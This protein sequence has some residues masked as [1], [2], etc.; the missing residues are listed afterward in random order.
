MQVRVVLD[1]QLFKPG[2]PNLFKTARITFTVRGHLGF[3]ARVLVRVRRHS[4][5]TDG[6]VGDDR[7]AAACG[8]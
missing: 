1:I 5:R 2:K 8:R 3:P 6:G 7:A 4:L